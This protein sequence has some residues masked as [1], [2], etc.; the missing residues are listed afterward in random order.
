MERGEEAG[1]A[2]LGPRPDEAK[3][4]TTV[5]RSAPRRAVEAIRRVAAASAGASREPAMPLQA[6]PE[7]LAQAA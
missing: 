3:R 7:G 6:V 5:H 2:E 1:L 4:P